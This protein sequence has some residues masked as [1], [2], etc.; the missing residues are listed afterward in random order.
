MIWYL[1][2]HGE[3]ESNNKRIYA[4]WNDEELTWTG[5]QQ[6]KTASKKLAVLEIDAIFCSP[7]KR[8]VQTAQILSNDLGV[9]YFTE[10]SFQELKL[11]NWEGKSEK[12]IRKIYATEWQ[13]WNTRPTELVVEGRE[14]LGELHE[15]VLGGVRKVR[16]AFQFDSPLIVS[17]V[18]I[19]RIIILYARKMQMDLYRTISVPNAK[20]FKVPDVLLR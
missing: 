20:I 19:I 10:S 15:R 16:D 13:T 9:E 1:M 3:I 2:R 18:S 11:G 8:A 6:I 14:T 17:H 4:G 12:L 5:K 7:L